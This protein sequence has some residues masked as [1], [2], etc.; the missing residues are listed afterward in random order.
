MNGYK[1]FYKSKQLDIY[2]NS[3]YEAQKLAA[4]QF[5]AKKS[6]EVTVILCELSGSQVTHNPST[7]GA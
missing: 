2:A 4:L 7:L 3:S 1:A 6:Y 5:K